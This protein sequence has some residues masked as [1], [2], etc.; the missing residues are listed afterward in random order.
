MS[1]DLGRLAECTIYTEGIH[2]QYQQEI[3]ALELCYESSIINGVVS[4]AKYD[5]CVRRC[6]ERRLCDYS[7]H[8]FET[9]VHIMMRRDASGHSQ[10]NSAAHRE[11]LQRVRDCMTGTIG[12]RTK[13]IYTILAVTVAVL[14]CWIVQTMFN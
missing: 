1:L 5:Q 8:R 4:N 7:Q 2:A 12:E 6:S 9:L 11:T 13:Q 10:L 3:I 14:L